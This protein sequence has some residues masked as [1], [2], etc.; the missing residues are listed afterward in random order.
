MAG[1][2]KQWHGDVRRKRKKEDQESQSAHVFF[3][4]MELHEAKHMYMQISCFCYESN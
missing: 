1:I 4:G 2:Q 3:H